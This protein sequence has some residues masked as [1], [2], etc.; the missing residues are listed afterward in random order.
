MASWASESKNY[1]QYLATYN[2]MTSIWLY[3]SFWSRGDRIRSTC[4]TFTIFAREGTC[5]FSQ[6]SHLFV[7]N[8]AT[9]HRLPLGSWSNQDEDVNKNFANLHIWHSKTIVSHAFHVHFSC[10]NISQTFSFSKF[11]RPKM[12]S[13][14]DDVS[15]WWQMF[16]FWSAGSNLIPKK[17]KHTQQA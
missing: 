10:L 9:N 7:D 11:S 15:I 2:C 3:W 14:V 17:L 4:G 1:V 8:V 13:F 16:N 6:L 5:L 12:T